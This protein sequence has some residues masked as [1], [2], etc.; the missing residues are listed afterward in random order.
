VFGDLFPTGFALD[1]LD[2]KSRIDA[3]AFAREHGCI[4]RS[5]G[6]KPIFE[7][8]KPKQEAKPPA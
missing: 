4:F 3:E 8:P 5:K 1:V 2:D 7:K 6:K